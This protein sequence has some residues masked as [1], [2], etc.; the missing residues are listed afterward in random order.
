MDELLNKSKKQVFPSNILLKELPDKFCQFFINKV[1]KIQQKFTNSND[2]M[3]PRTPF[4]AESQLQTLK[5]ATHEEIRKLIIASPTKS[6]SLDPIPTFLLKDCIDV[7]LPIITGIINASLA[8]SSVP[9]SFKKAVVTPL[10]KKASLDQDQ[11]TNYR[12]VSNLSFVSKLL[13]K[14]VSRRLHAHKHDHH[15][16]EVFQSAYRSGHSTETAVF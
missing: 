12:P 5:P 2:T 1:S 15:L 10:L 6:C 11:L 3:M 13:E 8:S 16:Y 9:S 4:P 7:F 14:V